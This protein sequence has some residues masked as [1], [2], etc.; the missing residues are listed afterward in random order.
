LDGADGDE[1][2]PADA[3]AGAEQGAVGGDRDVVL[4]GPSGKVIA[5]CTIARELVTGRRPPLMRR[6]T[7]SVAEKGTTPNR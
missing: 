5:G 7:N 2:E 1:V 3:P 4:G 6:P